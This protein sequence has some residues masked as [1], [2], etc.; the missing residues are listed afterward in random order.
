MVQARGSLPS[1]WEVGIEFQAPLAWYSSRCYRQQ[2]EDL[3]LSVSLCLS[4]GL[5]VD[6][7]AGWM[8]MLLFYMLLS[9]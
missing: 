6:Q 7:M 1:S 9:S 2:V 5:E 3:H 4:K 8:L